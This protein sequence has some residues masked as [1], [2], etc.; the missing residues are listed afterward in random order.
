MKKIVISI[1]LAVISFAVANKAAA[2]K[3]SSGIYKTVSDYQQSK[4]SYA[5]NYK[6]ENHQIKDN[7]LFNEDKIVVNHEGHTYKLDKNSTY[8]YKNS[9]GET[10]RFV[11][12]KEYRLLNPGESSMLYAYRHSTST[13]GAANYVTQYYFST[14][15]PS[16][17]I[18][19]TKE[20]LKAAY[21]NNH[22][23]HDAL[24]AT[25]KTDEDLASYDSFHKMYKINHLLEMSKTK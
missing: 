3:D 8:G 23:F 11:N 17:V 20:N 21:P 19:L 2:Q 15:A 22:K 16:A 4:L 18:A 7:F 13:K 25:F 12:K 5:I 6:T 1:S 9:K 14:D 24:D 10:F